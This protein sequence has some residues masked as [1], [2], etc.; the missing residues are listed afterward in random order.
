MAVLFVKQA[1]RT[2]QPLLQEHSEA[3]NTINTITAIQTENYSLL[4]RNH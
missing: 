1:K 2:I 3:R 4:L